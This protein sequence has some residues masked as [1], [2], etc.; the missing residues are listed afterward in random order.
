MFCFAAVEITGFEFEP[1]DKE[2]DSLD[3]FDFMQ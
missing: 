3:K 2:N 1:Y